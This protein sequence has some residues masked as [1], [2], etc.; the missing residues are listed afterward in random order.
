M[1]S[2]P[3]NQLPLKRDVLGYYLFLRKSNL[4]SNPAK[5]TERIVVDTVVHI[6]TMAYIKSKERCT[7]IKELKG[8]G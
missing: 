5:E 1:E 4:K 3:K 2:L 8:P 6:W 7:I